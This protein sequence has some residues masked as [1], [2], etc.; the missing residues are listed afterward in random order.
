MVDLCFSLRK[1]YRFEVEGKDRV[2]GGFVEFEFLLKHFGGAFW[3]A[4]GYMW[5][6]NPLSSL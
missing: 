2:R 4:V 5:S 3:E 6:L 1:E